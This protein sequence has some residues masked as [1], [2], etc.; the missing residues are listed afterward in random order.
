[1]D[2]EQAYTRVQ[3]T[4]S[5]LTDLLCELLA[6][7]EFTSSSVTDLVEE[8]MEAAT[9]LA[10]FPDQTQAELHILTSLKLMTPHVMLKALEK[11][12]H[13]LMRP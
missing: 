6:D 7:K 12:K 13:G 5:K 10:A 11:A 9:E 8:A 2:R 3:E 1:M 4:V